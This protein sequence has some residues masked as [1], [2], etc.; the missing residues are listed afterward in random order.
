M[1]ILLPFSSMY[2][3]VMIHN[4]KKSAFE[5]LHNSPML[6]LPI[7][8]WERLVPSLYAYSRINFAEVRKTSRV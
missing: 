8:E 6:N 7:S 5:W 4:T 3:L 2:T 1:G